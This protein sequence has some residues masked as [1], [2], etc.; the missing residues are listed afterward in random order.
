MNKS[1]A[2]DWDDTQYRY[3]REA[4]NPATNITEPASSGFFV[5]RAVAVVVLLAWAALISGC[6][7]PSE[8]QAMRD[9]AADARQAPSE[10][11]EQEAAEAINSIAAQLTGKRPEHISAADWEASQAAVRITLTRLEDK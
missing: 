4:K 9:M 3:P 5:A 7:G 11:A 1:P 2:I 8:V 6:S 10:V